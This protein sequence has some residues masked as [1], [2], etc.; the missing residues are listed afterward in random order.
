MSDYLD[1]FGLQIRKWIS[2]ESLIHLSQESEL[3]R[4]LTPLQVFKT[5]IEPSKPRYDV[6][7]THP[8]LF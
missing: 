5:T 7:F 3:N 6:P 4:V 2:N 1:D 8:G